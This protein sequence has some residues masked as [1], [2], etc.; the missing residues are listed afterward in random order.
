MSFGSILEKLAL[1]SKLIDKFLLPFV[2][3]LVREVLNSRDSTTFKLVL[4]PFPMLLS[5]SPLREI[6]DI[7]RSRVLGGLGTGKAHPLRWKNRAYAW[8]WS[9]GN[10]FESG[11]AQAAREKSMGVAE[12]P[13]L[14]FAAAS[15]DKSDV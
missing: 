15:A 14:W 1:S 4:K 7:N 11:R 8:L 5:S 13:R 3:H 12:I 10:R 9:D 6:R 2:L